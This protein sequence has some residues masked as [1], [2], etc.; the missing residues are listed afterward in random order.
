MTKAG[1]TART[2]MKVSDDL[3]EPGSSGNIEVLAHV[4]DEATLVKRAARTY[5]L[6]DAV[7]APFADWRAQTTPDDV[8]PVKS[9]VN[10]PGGVDPAWK[11]PSDAVHDEARTV[12]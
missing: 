11:A 2:V 8:D 10:Q 7:E 6:R 9:A 5:N 3:E 4:S 1:E 12:A